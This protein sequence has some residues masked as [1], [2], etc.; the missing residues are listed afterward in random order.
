MLRPCLSMFFNIITL[1]NISAHRRV[2]LIRIF[3]FLLHLR[4]DEDFL[5]FATAISFYIT[6]LCVCI[7]YQH[8]YDIILKSTTALKR[9]IWKKKWQQ[10]PVKTIYTFFFDLLWWE[11][12]FVSSVEFSHRLQPSPHWDSVKLSLNSQI[13]N[14]VCVVDTLPAT[15][16]FLE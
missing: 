16:S 13:F 12:N 6:Y 5:P 10:F 3:L 7:K 2:V 9:R 11:G 14:S 15:P 4:V 1:L 8:N